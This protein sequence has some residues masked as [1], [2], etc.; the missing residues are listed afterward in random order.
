MAYLVPEVGLDPNFHVPTAVSPIVA[1][2]AGNGSRCG[3]SRRPSSPVDSRAIR[4]ATSFAS[5]PELVK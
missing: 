4:M 2:P 5:L 3:G 1:V